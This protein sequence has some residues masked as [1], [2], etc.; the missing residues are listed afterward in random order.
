[1]KKFLLIFTFLI[2]ECPEIF[3]ADMNAG[4]EPSMAKISETV[5]RIDYVDL[6]APL[7][8]KRKKQQEKTESY[9]K[10]TN[11]NANIKISQE[12]IKKMRK[13]FKKVMYIPLR[14][15]QCLNHKDELGVANCAK[16][17]DYLAG[18]AKA[19]GGMMYV[20]SECDLLNLASLVYHALPEDDNTT[21]YGKRDDKLLK[22]LGIFVQDS[23]V[24]YWTSTEQGKTDGVVRMFSTQGSSSYVAP[25]DGSGYISEVFGKISYG[26]T[27]N[28]AAGIPSLKDELADKDKLVAI[29][30]Y[31]KHTECPYSKA[32][33]E[34]EYEEDEFE[35][36]DRP[37]YGNS[38]DEVYYKPIQG[39]NLLK[40]IN[41]Y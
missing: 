37:Y 15:K 9:K 10:K 5:K 28:K 25:R 41:V 40:G 18:V 31:G 11:R 14:Y 21:L 39:K 16:K 32:K 20:P 23:H 13:L 22:K 6:E 2:L 19:C 38:D 27:K 12:N 17:R 30:Y 35:A 24:F 26:T 1:M 7:S 34:Q 29:C 33:K 4:T 3:A 36:V 8:A